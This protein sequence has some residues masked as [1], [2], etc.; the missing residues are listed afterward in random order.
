MASGKGVTVCHSKEEALNAINDVFE[1]KFGSAGETLLLEECLQGP[2]VS[3]FAICDGKELLVLPTAQDHK[4]LLDND[5]GP[6]TGGM[7]AYSPANVIN[8]QQL[9]EVQRI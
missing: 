2:E 4:R 6:N 1:G 5:K 8:R 7:G 3:I 9:D